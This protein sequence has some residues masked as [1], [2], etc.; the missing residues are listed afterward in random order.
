M[1]AFAISFFLSLYT[2]SLFFPLSLAK[3]STIF[4]LFSS[5]DRKQYRFVYLRSW[6]WYTYTRTLAQSSFTLLSSSSCASRQRQRQTFRTIWLAMSHHRRAYNTLTFNLGRNL[7]DVRSH[8]KQVISSS[9][10]PA[11]RRTKHP[12]TSCDKLPRCQCARLAQI[13]HALS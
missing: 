7:T 6:Q 9:T 10:I 3:N 13:L 1:S 8:D 12:P 2:L 11:A 5:R 4:Q